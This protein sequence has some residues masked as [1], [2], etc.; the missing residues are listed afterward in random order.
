[1]LV[2]GNPACHLRPIRARQLFL[3]EVIIK[4]CGEDGKEG[5]VG[6]QWGGRWERRDG[7]RER[8]RRPVS[9]KEGRV[10]WFKEGFSHYNSATVYCILQRPY[11]D[12]VL[13]FVLPF[14]LRVQHL[15]GKQGQ[16]LLRGGLA[17]DHNAREDDLGRRMLSRVRSR[18][19]WI[20]IITA[21]WIQ[22]RWRR[23]QR[24]HQNLRC[25][26]WVSSSFPSVCPAVS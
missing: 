22:W 12:V 5:S 20:L 16:E 8:E 23:R 26:C 13:A 7:E 10:S 18:R 17:E 3:P 24:M 9:V 21:V 6:V 15:H 11:Y 14:R 4:R 2:F 1:M 19:K 25:S